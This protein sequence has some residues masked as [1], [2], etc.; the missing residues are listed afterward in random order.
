MEDNHHT[1]TQ[2]KKDRL[3]PRIKQMDII[4]TWLYHH[5]TISNFDPLC[6]ITTLNKTYMNTKPHGGKTLQQ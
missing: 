4:S 3:T 6:F 2:I 5:F 1:I